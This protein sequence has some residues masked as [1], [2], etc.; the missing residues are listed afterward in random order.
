MMNAGAIFAR[1]VE[2]PR[3]RFR[4]LTPEK[5]TEI[6]DFRVTAFSVDHS[7]YGSVAFLIEGQGK[8]VLY[9]GDL[10]LHG[11][12]PGMTKTLLDGVRDVDVDLLLMEGTLLGGDS[13]SGLNEYEL[14]KQITKHVNFSDGL[15]LASF[16]PQHIDR[17]VCFIKTAQRTRR[18]LVVD[19]YTAYAMHLIQSEVRIPSPTADK[20]IR[21]FYPQHSLASR[22][23]TRS[24]CDLFVAKQITLDEILTAPETHLMIF[25]P[26]MFDSDF[27]GELPER[28]CCVY[29]RWEGYLEQ[30]E[31]ML[32][33]DKLE[34]GGGN[35]LHLH[36]GGHC[37]VEDLGKL[38]RGIK[39]R[40]VAP[41]HTFEPS[42]FRDHFGN[43]Q[44]LS[45]G[46]PYELF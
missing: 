41:I 40:Q 25:R 37:V 14:E 12:K 42:Q 32:I 44:L 39:P 7:V 46:E 20:G 4:R 45:D 10:R 34:A 24:I 43:V 29:S 9:S 22:D 23:N 27:G 26:S 1:Q 13:L 21:V 38:A 5:P 35:L 18:T 30:P 11:R 31:W 28:T 3:G 15:V 6:G 2:I 33:R 16:S 36:T 19:V 8:T 17:L